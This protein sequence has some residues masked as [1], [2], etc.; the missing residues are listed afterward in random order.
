MGRCGVGVNPVVARVAPHYDEEP[1]VR[2]ARLRAV[3][4][5]GCPLGCAFCQNAEIRHGCFGRE[6]DGSNPTARD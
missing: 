2:A 6:I 1:C 5:S 3:F 4:F